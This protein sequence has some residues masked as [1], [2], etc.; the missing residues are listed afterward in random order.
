MSDEYYLLKSERNKKNAFPLKVTGDGRIVDMAERFGLKR[1]HETSLTAIYC[2]DFEYPSNKTK[3]KMAEKRKEDLFILKLDYTTNNVS[4][5]HDGIR[6]YTI[7]KSSK[8][9][10]LDAKFREIDLK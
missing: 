3:W 7:A 9:E 8:R 5:M 4:F 10:S 6:K 2:G 1:I